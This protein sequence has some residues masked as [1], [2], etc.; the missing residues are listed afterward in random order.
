MVSGY[1][2]E[3]LGEQ[4]IKVTYGGEET[5][6]KVNVK[7]YVTKIEVVP[8]DVTGKYNDELSQIISA[9]DIKYVVTYAKEGAKTPE[10]LTE[11][12]IKTTYNK[13][14][15]NKQ[16]L[17][18]EYEDED[19]NSATKGEKFEATLNVTLSDVVPKIT[20]TKT[21]KNKL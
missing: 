3:K 14:T 18:V 9:N 12:M 21:N 19:V 6:F 2:K 20:I 15:I 1:D 4:A 7:D 17:K 8:A 16:S 11:S 5:T 13:G 10:T